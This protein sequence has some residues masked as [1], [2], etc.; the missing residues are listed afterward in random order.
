MNFPRINKKGIEELVKKSR[1]IDG[2]HY[3]SDL[4]G[5]AKAALPDI[6]P[7]DSVPI[8][9]NYLF[10]NGAGDKVFSDIYEKLTFGN[11]KES[12]PQL[13]EIYRK[14]F[15]LCTDDAPLNGDLEL[16]LVDCL[17]VFKEYIKIGAKINSEREP[18]KGSHYVWLDEINRIGKEIGKNLPKQTIIK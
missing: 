10:H 1:E 2:G 18:L 11:Y 12:D 15:A 13:R 7:E 14:C 6:K 17:R 9:L 4:A 5:I 3:Y 8:I 16:S